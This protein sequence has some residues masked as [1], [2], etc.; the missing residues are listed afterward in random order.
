MSGKNPVREKLSRG[1][2]VI[3]AMLRLP[4]LAAA[5]IMACS[6]VDLICIDNEHYP[7]DQE[8][9]R[10]IVT[11]VECFGKSCFIRLPNGDPSRVAQYLDMG[12]AGIKIPHVDTYEQAKAVVD[13]VKFAPVGERGFCPITRAARYGFADTPEGFAREANRDTMIA[14]MLESK[15]ALE[16]I[17]EILTIPQVDFIAIGP[18]DVAASYGHPGHNDAPQVVEAMAAAKKKVLA[19]HLLRLPM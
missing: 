19:S 12:L 1:E 11:A 15:T 14:L 8:T 13:A 17:D 16:N 10:G 6:G 2:M 5:E 7:F 9:V 3:A 4:D 18:S